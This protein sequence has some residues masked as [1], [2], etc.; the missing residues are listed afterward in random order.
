MHPLD[1]IDLVRRKPDIFL[2]GFKTECT[3]QVIHHVTKPKRIIG[4]LLDSRFFEIHDN[5][6][7]CGTSQFFIDQLHALV[8]LGIII[9]IVDKAVL[10]FEHG[11]TGYR[12]DCQYQCRCH[13][14]PAVV[15]GNSGKHCGKGIT[16]FLIGRNRGAWHS[17]QQRRKQCKGHQKRNRK[18]DGHHPAKIN[19]R[20]DAADRER[21][22]CQ[23]SGQRRIKARPYH[24]TGSFQHQIML[25]RI[26]SIPA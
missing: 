19:D 18:A 14:L 16:V 8:D 24:F 15:L 22:K 21:S 3:R 10:H 13:D 9:E 5:I 20:F 26:W 17:C 12:N 7:R 11:N 2:S 1:R 25:I 4:R 23:D 6:Q